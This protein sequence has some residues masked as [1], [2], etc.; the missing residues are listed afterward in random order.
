MK[1]KWL[2]GYKATLSEKLTATDRLLPITN[3]RELAEMLGED[4]TYLVI[5]D[6]TGAEIVKAYRFGNEVKIERGQDGT[7][8]KAFPTG[9]CVKWEA[10]E[11]GITETVCNG[12]FKCQDKLKDGEKSCCCEQ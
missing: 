5:N 4:H 10:T 9:S 3:A 6:G 8:S 11:S 1:Y 2:N 7:T 12:D